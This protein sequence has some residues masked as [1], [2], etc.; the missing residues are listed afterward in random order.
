MFNK[1]RVIH[2]VVSSAPQWVQKGLNVLP[3]PLTN[4]GLQ[5]TLNQFFKPD[6]RAGRFSFL[7]AKTVHVVV[8]DIGL[9]FYIALNPHHM[10]PELMVSNP[11]SQEADILFRGDM[12]DLLLLITQRVDPDTLFFRRKLMLIGDT[13]LGLELKNLLDTIELHER[14]P[15]PLYQLSS[16][17]AEEIL[18]Q[19]S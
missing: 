1:N 9:A 4:A 14:L 12:N 11:G 15:K 8:A 3:A 7:A 17:V 18:L 2:K 13:E 10:R 5:F 6:L 19:R 16:E